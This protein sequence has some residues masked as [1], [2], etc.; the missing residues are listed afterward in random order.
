MWNR[1]REVVPY[2]LQQA[3][4]ALSEVKEDA[5][6]VLVAI[7]VDTQLYLADQALM[8]NKL[9]VLCLCWLF[10]HYRATAAGTLG[11]HFEICEFDICPLRI[12]KNDFSHPLGFLRG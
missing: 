4:A 5:Y 7:D 8:T 12:A 6:N 1:C 11:Y 2:N 10:Q 3:E 9:G